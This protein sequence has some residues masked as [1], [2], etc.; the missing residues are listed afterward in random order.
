MRVPRADP[1][2]HHEQRGGARIGPFHAQI[3]IEQLAGFGGQGEQAQLVAFPRTR[4]WPSENS[5]STRFKAMIST[6]R[7]PCRSMR[8]TIARS[9][10][11][12]KLDQNRATS[13]TERGTIL[14]RGSRTRNLL[15]ATRARP[16]PMGLPEGL[17]ESVGDLA[18]ASGNSLRRARSTSATRSLMVA[19]EDAAPE[20]TG[21]G[22][23]RA[24]SIR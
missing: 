18:G 24:R 6:E 7:S 5:T 19:A 22:C 3:V 23:N 8:P 21:N 4:S 10:A 15:M 2:Q 1:F 11:E 17:L 12:R 13:S 14:R 16:S 9:R 20:R